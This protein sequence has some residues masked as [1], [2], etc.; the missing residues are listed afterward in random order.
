VSN[1]RSK[2]KVVNVSIKCCYSGQLFSTLKW[3]CVEFP[4]LTTPL[5]AKML[6]FTYF[7][8][9]LRALIKSEIFKILIMSDFVEDTKFNQWINRSLYFSLNCQQ[10]ELFDNDKQKR[11]K[12]P[13]HSNITNNLLKNPNKT[14]GEESKPYLN[15]KSKLQNIL[16]NWEIRLYSLVIAWSINLYK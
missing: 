10:H 1:H 6:V 9:V 14:A 7:N 4:L 11:L 8:I 16:F 13:S 5:H 12:T 2:K 15:L 3:V